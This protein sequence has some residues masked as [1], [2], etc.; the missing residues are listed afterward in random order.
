MKRYIHEHEKHS[1]AWCKYEGG[2]GIIYFVEN[3]VY[4]EKF[5]F[6]IYF[7]LAFRVTHVSYLSFLSVKISFPFFLFHF[8]FS[9]FL[10]YSSLLMLL[11]F[12]PIL[13]LYYS[14]VVVIIT[15]MP[16]FVFR[17]IFHFHFTRFFYSSLFSLVPIFLIFKV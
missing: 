12:I 2:W 8:R 10:L 13:T 4:G 6:A 1:I 15:M 7:N 9:R 11:L 14:N 3:L 17:S 5:N 16:S